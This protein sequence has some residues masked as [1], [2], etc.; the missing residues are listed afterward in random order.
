MQNWIDRIVFNENSTLQSQGYE[1]SFGFQ[2]HKPKIMGCSHWHGHI[3]INYLFNCSADYLI[4][5]KKLVYLKENA[6][7]LKDDLTSA[8]AL[9]V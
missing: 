8:L 7:D 9:I 1:N 5:G 6:E 4:N 2:R 3:E